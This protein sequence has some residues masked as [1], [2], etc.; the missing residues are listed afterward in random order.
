[1]YICM[2]T[3]I[4]LQVD[5]KEIDPIPFPMLSSE[6]E[7]TLIKVKDWVKTLKGFDPYKSSLSMRVINKEGE[8][9]YSLKPSRAY[10]VVSRVEHA[11]DYCHAQKSDK[12]S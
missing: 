1:M 9:L 6:K 7:K 4:Y 5:G 2:N 12:I 10:T 3:Y 8:P 11:I